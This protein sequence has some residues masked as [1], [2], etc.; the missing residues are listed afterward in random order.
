VKLTLNDAENTVIKVFVE[1]LRA[2]KRVAA[3][4]A[5]RAIAGACVSDI[6]RQALGFRAPAR[7]WG[8]LFDA[9]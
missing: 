5:F 1:L 4:G 9:M 8:D 7:T 2:R 6:I 3:I